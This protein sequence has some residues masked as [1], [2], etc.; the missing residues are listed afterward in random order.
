MS[1]MSEAIEEILETH[2]PEYKKLP[3]PKSDD[4]DYS[5]RDEF[6]DDLTEK[7]KYNIN[8]EV[9]KTTGPKDNDYLVCFEIGRLEDAQTIQ[10]FD[11]LYDFD[12][13][14]WEYQH[15]FLTEEYEKIEEGERKDRLKKRIDDDSDYKIYCSGD[16]IRL[17]ENDT[18]I[19]G[20]LISVKWFIFYELES[21]LSKL[22]EDFLPYSF[23]DDL[24]NIETIEKTMNE[25]D[26]I[27]RYDAQGREQELESLLTLI[28][29]F[30]NNEMILMID[31]ELSNNPSY[32]GKVF[33]E[34]RGYTDT[35]FDPFTSYIFWDEE[36]LQT[37]RT[38][39]FVEDFSSI[40]EPYEI[41]KNI[42]D[43]LMGEVE[44][45]FKSFSLKNMK[46][47]KNVAR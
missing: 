13:S 36:S 17:F 12:K 42:I 43:N 34:H 30:E 7:E 41:I 39:N 2:Y 5:A 14:W 21:Y 1:Q 19:Y 27:K 44:K 10:D 33:R 37:V 20:Q 28:R 40:E 29:E 9:L 24:K 23:K 22:Q 3:I 4:F 25:K 16:W 35:N 32:S 38:T 18:F 46:E 8:A 47:F 31:E 26:P 11:T 6:W 45:Y 15:S